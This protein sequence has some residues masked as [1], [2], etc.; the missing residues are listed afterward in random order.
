MRYGFIRDHA[1]EYPVRQLCRA[2]EVSVGGYYD[3]LDRPASA[4][5]QRREALGEKIRAIHAEVKRR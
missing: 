3:W 2:L 1:A 4:T 5:Q